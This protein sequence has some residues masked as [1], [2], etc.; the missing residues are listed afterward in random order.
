M[1]DAGTPRSRGGAAMRGRNSSWVAQKASSR[2]VMGAAAVTV[3]ATSV[4]SDTV[5]GATAE[6][7]RGT[8]MATTVAVAAGV[9]PY[10]FRPTTSTRRL[11]EICTAASPQAG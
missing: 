8:A 3:V 5:G 7:S 11:A 10:L 6:S 2:W 9:E 4:R 1:T